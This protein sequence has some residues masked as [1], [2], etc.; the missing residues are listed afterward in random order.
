M[1]QAETTG[2]ENAV[3]A[4][5]TRGDRQSNTSVTTPGQANEKENDKDENGKQGEKKD[6]DEIDTWLNKIKKGKKG[7]KRHK[8]CLEWEI[9]EYS[10]FR[11]LSKSKKFKNEKVMR[12]SLD[13]N[14]E[15]EPLIAALIDV[16]EPHWKEQSQSNGM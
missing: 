16:L 14:E 15:H 9:D 10:T 13:P 6:K 12:S 5:E 8:Q 4:D 1:A 2:S 7:D 11:Q 3:A